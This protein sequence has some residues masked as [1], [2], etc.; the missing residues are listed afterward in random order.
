MRCHGRLGNSDL[1]ETAKQ[2]LLLPKADRFMELL[3]D[4]L[5]IR[6]LHSGVAQ[7]FTQFCYKYWIP[8]DRSVVQRKLRCCTVC[9]VN[10]GHCRIYY[11]GPLY[12][13]DKS[14]SKK[15]WICLF[16]F[17]V[18]SAIDFE[19]IL[20]MS[21]E[22]FLLGLRI[23]VARH[24]SPLEIISDNASQFKLANDTIDKLW[25][26]VLTESDVISYSM[27]EKIRWNFIDE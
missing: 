25:R 20:D 11:F 8:S 24:G 13:N 5:H 7:I 18:T 15:V 12:D 22:M 3:K 6:M 19:H 27:N 1:D 2:P 16:T 26:Q 4:R 23:L 10:A 9:K 21:A 14:E 17:L